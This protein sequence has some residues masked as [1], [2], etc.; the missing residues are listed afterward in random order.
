MD[1]EDAAAIAVAAIATVGTVA[2]ASAT[3]D[4]GELGAQW[5]ATADGPATYPGMDIAWDVPIRMS[6]GVILKANVYRPR[7]RTGGPSTPR[8]RRS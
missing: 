8:S 1:L 3:P 5:T 6:D 2:P 7:T 4:A